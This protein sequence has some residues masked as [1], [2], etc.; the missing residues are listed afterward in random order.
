MRFS[1]LSLLALPLLGVAAEEDVFGQYQ[2]QFQ[3]YL[4]KFGSYIPVPNRHDAAAAAE[5]K[6]SDKKMS[7]LTIGNF[8]ETLYAPVLAKYQGREA[9][10][11]QL[12]A[13]EP[14]Q[15]WILVSG[16][17]KT[18]RGKIPILPAPNA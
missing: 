6:A 14:E 5:A 4:D 11:P 15:W 16:G 8:K 10:A 18:C 13:V 12:S 3:N 17:N 7:V 1:T 2:A 9:E